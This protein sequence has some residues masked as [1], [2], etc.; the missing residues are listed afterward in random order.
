MV[1]DLPIFWHSAI[2]RTILPRAV[3][4]TLGF[5]F[6]KRIVILPTSLIRRLLLLS[7]VVGL[8]LLIP[9][10]AGL[11]VDWHVATWPWGTLGSVILGTGVASLSLYRIIVAAYR[12]TEA[13]HHRA[14]NAADK[15]DTA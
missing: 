2:I 12:E 11:W 13:H 8:S 4:Y 6:P 3:C 9:L 15:E 5:A 14:V 1:P 10:A 7:G